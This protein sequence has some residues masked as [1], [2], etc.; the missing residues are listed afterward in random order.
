MA[1]FARVLDGVVSDVI[2]V[3]NVE[4]ENLDFPDSEPVG[5]AFIATLD[6]PGEWLQCSYSGAFRG[7]YPGVGFTFDPVADTFSPPAE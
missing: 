2:V 1:H 5:Q 4:L 6:L 7:S 3:A